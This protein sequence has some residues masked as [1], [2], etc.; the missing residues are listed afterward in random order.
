MLPAT[1]NHQVERIERFQSLQAGYY[2]RATK[3]ILH[4]GIDEGMVLLIE[5]IRW[6]D[7][8][9]HTIILRPHPEKIGKST[10]LEMPQED[11]SVRRTYFGYGKHKFLVNDFLD[12]FEFEPDHQH[13]RGIELQNVQ[14]RITDIQNELLDAQK[15]PSLLNDFVEEGLRQW[16]SEQ[17]PQTTTSTESATE[18]ETASLPAVQSQGLITLGPGAVADAIN[19]G[20]TIESIA[21]LKQAASQQHQIATIK[22]K[23]IQ[24]KTT[25]IADTI[26][27]MTPFYEEQA[28][29]ELAKT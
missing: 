7:D 21:S 13:I 11:G 14:N 4:E 3:P 2:W 19:S 23:W 18:F 26:K 8:K 12:A 28:A 1:I 17:N 25:E 9:P 24:S 20:I 6:V 10:Y 5:S 15:D 27:A 22:S 16:E 29:A